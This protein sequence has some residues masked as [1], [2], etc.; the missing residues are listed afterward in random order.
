MTDDIRKT[1]VAEMSARDITQERMADIAEVSRTQLS[2][3]LNGHSNAL[4]KAWEA[5]FEELGLRL[6]AVPKNAR[7]TV[8]RDL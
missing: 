5:I 4:P 8:S 7:V 2:R 1:V 6:V 3:M